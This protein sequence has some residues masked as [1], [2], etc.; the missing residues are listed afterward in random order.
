VLALRSRIAAS[1][2]VPFWQNDLS[3]LTP[4]PADALARDAH[5][6]KEL[7]APDVRY[8]IAVRAATS[9]TPATQR[10]P[11]SALDHARAHAWLA[12][13]DI[14][15]RYLPSAARNARARQRCPCRSLARA[16]DTAVAATPF[17]PTCSTP[18]SP[19][20]KPRARAAARAA[21]SRRHA[22]AV[23]R[24]RPAAATRDHATALVSL[25]GSRD[26]TPSRASRSAK[27][28]TLVD[29]KQPPNRW[30]SPIASACCGRWPRPRAVDRRGAVA[31][32]L[33]AR[34]WRVLAPMALTTLVILAVLRLCGVELTLFH[35]VAL[36]LAAGLGLDYAC[37]SNTRATIAKSN[38]RTLHGLAG[39]QRDDAAGVRLARAV[40]D[41]GACARS[42]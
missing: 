30:S 39:L 31:L 29:L 32:A 6:R 19:T 24:R 4:V 2:P 8:V 11:A 28:R 23:A 34:A 38:C 5:L 35:L 42:A 21:R 1:R 37:S 27:A 7:G 16:L 9:K 22:A 41:P 36:I 12:G 17:A 26:R 25:I 3:R 20:S 13:F 10:T 15:A 18:S 14:R 33:A 40:V